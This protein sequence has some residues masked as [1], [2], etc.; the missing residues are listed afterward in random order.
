MKSVKSMLRALSMVCLAGLVITNNALWAIG[1]LAFSAMSLG[2][3][4]GEKRKKD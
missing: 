4:I 2:I 3:M 1:L